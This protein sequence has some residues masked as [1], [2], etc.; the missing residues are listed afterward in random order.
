[1]VEYNKVIQGIIGL[2]EMY[3]QMNMKIPHELIGNLG[4]FYALDKLH[5]EGFKNIVK[6]EPKSVY[7]IWLKDD[8]VRIEVR[9]SLLKNEVYSKKLNPL[10]YGWTVLREYQPELYYD[11]L[12][13]IAL[14]DTYKNP[15]FYIFNSD[16]LNQIT[17]VDMWLSVR[18]KIHLFTD[19]K[20]Y[21]NAVAS[22]PLLVTDYEK[23]I[24]DNPDKFLNGWGKIKNNLPGKN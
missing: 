18:R 20:S 8:N 16:E 17:D 12:I 6:M 15:K 13:G 24:N 10:Y 23:Y 19:K 3:D 21:N 9:A 1:M 4:E 7:D 2:K 22:K 14:D 5:N 11:I